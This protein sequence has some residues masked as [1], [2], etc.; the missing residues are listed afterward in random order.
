M[1]V[2]D[3]L[4][5][6]AQLVDQEINSEARR[7]DL[8]NRLREIYSAQGIEVPD[9][10]LEDGVNALEERRFSYQPPKD[11]FAVR[12][13]KLYVN[14]SQW[15][16]PFVYSVAAVA[17]LFV[18]YQALVAAPAKSRAAAIERQITTELPSELEAAYSAVAGLAQEDKAKA[19]ADLYYS[20]GKSALEAENV[21]AAEQNINA[22]TLLESDLN[23]VYEVHVRYRGGAQSGFFRG[24]R[25]QPGLQN[26]YLIV[27][28]VDAAGNVITVPIESEEAEEKGRVDKWAQRVS[29]SVF[30]QIASDKRDD[31][32]I[33]NDVIGR[34][35]RGFLAPTYS[36]DTPGGAILTW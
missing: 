27:E 35:A 36:V 3:T 33:Q 6:R 2:V 4:R 30:D 28:A 14:R 32:I 22:M 34:K 29:Q 25:D 18:G 5:H 1:D 12:L 7:V 31:Q 9:R 16:R 21:T 26:F 23:A 11:G 13:A 10:I 15:G 20:E 17:A 24:R 19:L 8:L